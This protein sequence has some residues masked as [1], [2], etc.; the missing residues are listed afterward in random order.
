MFIDGSAREVR[1][2]TG[3]SKNR[4]GEVDAKEA[5]LARAVLAVQVGNST[6]GMGDRRLDSV[7]LCI[8]RA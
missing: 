2:P 3:E 6:L 5:M 4:L 1:I 7:V 8:C